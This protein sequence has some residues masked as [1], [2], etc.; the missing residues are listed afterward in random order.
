M[1]TKITVYMPVYNGAEH[2]AVAIES[3][4][5]QTY[6]DFELLI[7]DNN[8]DDDT[9]EIIQRYLASGKIRF[10]RQSTNIGMINNGIFCLDNIH[11]GYFAG[12]CHDDYFCDRDALKK[13]AEVLNN[14][15]DIAAV[16]GGTIFIDNLGTPIMKRKARYSGVVDNNFV[17]KKSI[18]LNRSLFGNLIL[19]RT[20]LLDGIR[21]DK[22]FY[23]T[24]DVEFS[25]AIG[26]NRKV[27]FF[28]D[29]LFALR[30]HKKNNTAR[31]YSQ[32]RIELLKIANKHGINL[33]YLEKASMLFNYIY[34]AAQKSAFFYYLDYIRK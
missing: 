29:I 16:Y 18:I 11:T 23:Y 19:G 34:T 15:N 33:T 2:I 21:P 28:T 26:L 7:S 31:V 24:S 9:V 30:F 5:A 14:N 32:T 3:V 12:L 27:F 4:L 20:S 6:D 17:A 1:N 13:A 25:T 10:Y 8:S 22:D